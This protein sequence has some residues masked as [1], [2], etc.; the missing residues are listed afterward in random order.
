LAGPVAFAVDAVGPGD[1]ALVERRARPPSQP[2]VG[3]VADQAVV[4]AV[5]RLVGVLGPDGLLPRL[6]LV[7][8]VALRPEAPAHELRDRAR[9][10]RAAPAEAAAPALPPPT[11]RAARGRP[12]ARGR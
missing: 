4:E 6:P 5:A 2:L 9:R 3:G 12:A 8:A 7:V 11:P 1:A 10:R